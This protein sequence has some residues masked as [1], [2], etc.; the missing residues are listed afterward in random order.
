MNNKNVNND[1]EI[2]QRRLLG[3]SKAQ[4]LAIRKQQ[5][6]ELAAIKNDNFTIVDGLDELKKTLLVDDIN[7]SETQNEDT[8]EETNN[9]VSETTTE[10]EQIQSTNVKEDSDQE[11]QE[12]ITE[13]D[14]TDYK[15]PL[16]DKV[17]F[18]TNELVIEE[19]VSDNSNV[20]EAEEKVLDNKAIME[21]R[22]IDDIN[23][24]L[25]IELQSNTEPSSLKQETS[26]ITEPVIEEI[27]T[28]QIEPS[29]EEKGEVKEFSQDEKIKEEVVA[30]KTKEIEVI[31]PKPTKKKSTSQ[32]KSTSKKSTAKKSTSTT[33][34]K[35]A[36]KT[37]VQTDD[38][39]LKIRGEEE[40]VQ[41]DQLMDMDS[42]ELL[43]SVREEESTKNP[44]SFFDTK[45]KSASKFDDDD[46]DSKGVINNLQKLREQIM[47]Q[48]RLEKELMQA[49][50]QLA[51]KKELDLQKKLSDLEILVK[52]EDFDEYED[53]HQ[54]ELEEEN[55]RLT[56]ELE[57]TKLRLNNLLSI[58]YNNIP[59]F[60]SQT[61]ALS[62]QFI[63]AF[64][65]SNNEEI[66]QELLKI[67]QEF[68]ELSQDQ[69]LNRQNLL[70]AHKQEKIALLN[71]NKTLELRIKDYERELTKLKAEIA[72]ITKE[73]P[74]IKQL[75]E[76]HQAEIDSI[77][78]NYRN[79]L[80]KLTE[81]Y[82]LKMK[83]QG[84][85]RGLVE[86]YLN[87]LKTEREKYN[88][89]ITKLQRELE[90][91]TY[92]NI[93]QKQVIKD[94]EER[95]HQ[96]LDELKK[97]L[98]AEKQNFNEFKESVAR[99][100][101]EKIIA[102]QDEINK[103]K[104][105]IQSYKEKVELE[106]ETKVSVLIKKFNEEKRILLEDSKRI[107]E[108]LTRELEDTHAKVTGLENLLSD[109]KYE[110]EKLSQ[111]VKTYKEQLAEERNNHYEIEQKLFNDLDAKEQEIM[112]LKQKLERVT[113]E[114]K[115]LSYYASLVSNLET[116]KKGYQPYS[117]YPSYMHPEVDNVKHYYEQEIARR[118][119]IIASMQKS[120]HPQEDR[121][122]NDKISMLESQIQDLGTYIK[123]L[124][125]D[126]RTNEDTSNLFKELSLELE[127]F[128]EEIRQE[129]SKHKERLETRVDS[130]HEE[131]IIQPFKPQVEIL[132]SSKEESAPS[133]NLQENLNSVKEENVAPTYKPQVEDLYLEKEKITQ[134]DDEKED[135]IDL[136]TEPIQPQYPSFNQ[137]LEQE[138]KVTQ[139]QY[140]EPVEDFKEENNHH[141]EQS[142]DWISKQEDTKDEEE[143][144]EVESVKPNI[145][146]NLRTIP[147]T[148]VNKSISFVGKIDQ[149]Y[150]HKLNNI[151]RLQQALENRKI[152]CIEKF[153]LDLEKNQ[154]LVKEHEEKI[155]DVQKRIEELNIAFNSRQ[156]FGINAKNEYEKE[157]TRLFLELQDRQEKLRKVQEDDLRKLNLRHK[158][159]LENIEEQLRTLQEEEKDLKDSFILRQQ[160]LVS[161]QK[162]ENE[163]LSKLEEEHTQNDFGRVIESQEEIKQKR[164][165][166]LQVQEESASFEQREVEPISE[167][168]V[169]TKIEPTVEFEAEPEI[170]NKPEPEVENKAEPKVESMVAPMAE[171]KDETSVKTQELNDF[172]V[173]TFD[174]SVEPKLEETTNVQNDS[175][176]QQLELEVEEKEESQEMAR[177]RTKER[178][179]KELYERYS[180][181]EKKLANDFLDVRRYK[182][183]KNE[184][185]GYDK[186][187]E[188]KCSLLKELESRLSQETNHEEIIKIKEEIKET[189]LRISNLKTRIAFLNKQ[190]E[191]IDK[192]KQVI[193]YI[194]ITDKLDT[195]K[196][197][198]LKYA[199]IREQA[200][201]EN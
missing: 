59:V 20:L 193:Q 108:Q 24:P 173:K 144:V 134:A 64:N 47:I 137:D 5:A 112:K 72:R 35:V 170:E 18:D 67:Q 60:D 147:H 65:N 97:Q 15:E 181:A 166:N 63:N 58:T 150:L 2:V 127:H 95:Y 162:R 194:K 46:D 83:D 71:E 182:A 148:N 153:K 69:Q 168:E 172:D 8:D 3:D 196:E 31:K 6:E 94:N 54:Y 177:L 13:Q 136:K 80:A 73:Q 114:D 200:L 61:L 30:D 102:L 176:Q 48:K 105:L 152:E 195:M 98:E 180:N 106:A 160:K 128:K 145:E 197:I 40:S 135:E 74:D 43:K 174:N 140:D 33:K 165:Q 192:N 84:Q 77:H 4:L 161:K 90:K 21:E 184:K 171:P 129:L 141:I 101:N 11:L 44:K 51:Q 39:L 175:H 38:N 142:P 190:M 125:Q 149:E 91:A 198:L 22:V 155:A 103:Q 126:K 28:E 107:Q 158:N 82:E 41:T 117:V 88:Q 186:E 52:E 185:L 110:L 138:E 139:E 17:L 23:E 56:N 169:E 75:E 164:F 36:N 100:K 85:N 120:N 183:I 178:E 70:M 26:E 111:R 16:E 124:N 79:E 201:S 53:P 163:I 10:E 27:K 14:T 29:K 66:N 113:S 154:E 68:L 189:N 118:D 116:P 34:R 115:G 57:E 76:K 109:Y 78:N 81:E 151:R 87:K 131:K 130:L 55:R 19:K 104:L 133:F 62:S 93:A 121:E 143:K 9:L 191:A 179:L 122:F 96:Q 25:N 159:D 12:E 167:P 32:S 187:Y 92:L 49:E 99:E 86:E 157:K 7:N 119:Q 50:A 156:D 146:I 89:D 45:L 188:K 199:S 123:S 1:R 132:N 42:K 37:S